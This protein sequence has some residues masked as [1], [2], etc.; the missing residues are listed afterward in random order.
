MKKKTSVCFIEGPID[1]FDEVQ[2]YWNNQMGWVHGTSAATAFTEDE[3]RG[4]PNLPLETTGIAILKSVSVLEFTRAA[5]FATS[6][7]AFVA[8]AAVNAMALQEPI[9]AGPGKEVAEVLPAIGN[10]KGVLRTEFKK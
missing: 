10:I 6:N 4:F 8:D 1:P 5:K 2:M 7:D 9:V 3:L